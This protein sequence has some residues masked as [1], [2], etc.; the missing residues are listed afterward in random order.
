MGSLT[1]LAFRFLMAWSIV[2]WLEAF[3]TKGLSFL[4]EICGVIIRPAVFALEMFW[5]GWNWFAYEIAE[6]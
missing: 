2:F 4:A 3:S 5:V 1:E 6:M